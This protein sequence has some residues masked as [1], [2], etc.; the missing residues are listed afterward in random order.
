[1]AWGNDENDGEKETPGKDVW[2]NPT[3]RDIHGNTPKDIWWKSRGKRR[4]GQPT[5]RQLGK[6]IERVGQRREGASSSVKVFL[7]PSPSCSLSTC[8]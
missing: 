6:P 3:P 7:A 8:I 2:G 1:M 4:V 5:Q